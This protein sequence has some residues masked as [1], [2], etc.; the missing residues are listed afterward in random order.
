MA[1]I[2]RP[3]YPRPQFVREDWLN[4]NGDWQ[5][6]IDTGDSGLARGLLN[7]ELSG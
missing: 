1:K 3:E 2:P 5:F 6:E 7:R 4:L